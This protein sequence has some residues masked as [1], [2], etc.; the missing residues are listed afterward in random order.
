MLAL[1][2]AYTR[3]VAQAVEVQAVVARVAEHTVQHYPHA[4]LAGLAAQLLKVRVC[5]QEGVHLVIIPGVVAVVAAR[6]E[7]GVEV[8]HAD[9]QV[10]EVGQFGDD[11]LQVA[12]E[13][14]HSLAVALGHVGIEQGRI[15]P[16][17]VHFAV[18]PPGN[19]GLGAVETVRENLVHDAVAQVIRG[20]KGRV[21]HR[22]LKRWRRVLVNGAH[23]AQLVRRIATV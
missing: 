3:V 7:D 10:L 4:Q 15:I 13:E 14:I 19:R 18:R 21:V 16:V 9:T 2:G 17:L 20:I 6:A 5:A 12:A 23:P 1:V 11:A 8:E 22:D